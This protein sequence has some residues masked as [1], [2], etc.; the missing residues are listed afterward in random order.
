MNKFIYKFIIFI[1]IVAILILSIR[2]YNLI[3]I[4]NF[5]FE[6]KIKYLVIGDSYTK[7]AIDQKQIPNLLNLSETSEGYLFSYSKLKFI[8]DNNN[9][10]KK[11]FIGLSFHNVSPSNEFSYSYAIANNNIIKYFNVLDNNEKLILLNYD[12]QFVTSF[13]KK[14]LV[15]DLKNIFRNKNDF[16][17][18]NSFF[19]RQYYI[20]ELDK[21]F[22]DFK[23]VDNKMKLSKKTINK[24]IQYVYYS[25]LSYNEK[26]SINTLYLFK[27]MELCKSKNID[28]VFVST[29]IH[30]EYFRNIP[31]NIKQKY[32]KQSNVEK[33]SYFEMFQNAIK[34]TNNSWIRILLIFLLGLLLSLELV[35]QKSFY[36]QH[37]T[38]MSSERVFIGNL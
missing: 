20:S 3:L 30:D 37:F 29:P 32:Y 16:S 25:S 6:N 22:K 34:T 10:V 27:I 5:K 9:E 15:Y 12:P 31:E 35:I 4:K 7:L 26:K 17:D 18:L 2:V 14:I 11:I 36:W 19:N 33:I 1:L 13:L 21:V 8:L 38:G 24:R 28:L 23:I